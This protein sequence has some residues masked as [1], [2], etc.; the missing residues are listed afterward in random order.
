[1]AWAPVN[2]AA[3][4]CAA[5]GKKADTVKNKIAAAQNIHRAEVTM[6]LPTKSP[7]VER[8]FRG[9][10]RAHAVDGTNTRVRHAVSRGMVLKGELLAW[11]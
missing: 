8:N 11:F 4:Y 10:S 9:I 3:W 2:L 5:E 1:M 6:K 7:Q